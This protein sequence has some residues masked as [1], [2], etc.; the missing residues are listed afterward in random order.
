M[1]LNKTLMIMLFWNIAKFGKALAFGASIYRFKSCYSIFILQIKTAHKNMYLNLIF[2]PL[3]G[4]FSA[5]LLGR[6]LGSNGAAF[7]TVTC[8]FLS[9]LI[10]SFIFFEVALMECCVYIKFCLLYT[11]PSPRD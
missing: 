4:S 1:G 11:S 10:S 9:F 2:L 7:I 6:R 8:L 5:G 3:I